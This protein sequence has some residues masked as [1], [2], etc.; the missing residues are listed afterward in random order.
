M[1]PTRPYRGRRMPTAADRATIGLS[2]DPHAE[3][4][5]LGIPVLREWL[6]DTLGVWAPQH[7]V[8][9]IADGLSLVEERCVLAH[10]LEHILAGDVGCGGSA[11]LRAEHRADQRAA[12]KLI[13]VSDFCRVRQW[14]PDQWQMA[15]E[16]Q[17]TPW[18]LR[19][20]MDDLE[21]AS[22]WPGMSKIAG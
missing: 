4:E 14:A 9:I 16:L 19:A 6:R 1:P 5:H 13:A 2:Y 17:V 12:R 11:G 15:D 8:V 10:E 22:R 21:G 18:M 7:Q 20:R 3:L